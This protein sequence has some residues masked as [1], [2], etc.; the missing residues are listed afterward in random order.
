MAKKL[1]RNY[2]QLVTGTNEKGE[3]TFET[4]LTPHFISLDVMYEAVDVME[5]LESIEEKNNKSKEPES[6]GKII[7]KQV[8]IM[9]GVV[10]N[11]YGGQFDVKALKEGLH[12]P[13]MREELQSQI[14]FIAAGQQDNETKKFVE[15]LS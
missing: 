13:N 5:E 11:I 8:D 4:Y 14:E 15:S 1:K 12:A 10:V 6:A 2:I 9:M 7:R 3:P